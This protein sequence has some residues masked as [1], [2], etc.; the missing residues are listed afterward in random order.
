MTNIEA[1]VDNVGSAFFN[2]VPVVTVHKENIYQVKETLISDIQVFNNFSYL[3]DI[4]VNFFW[5]I[6]KLKA[7]D[8]HSIMSSVSVTFHSQTTLLQNCSFLAVDC[9]L[10]GLGERKRLNVAAVDERWEINHCTW[11]F[12]IILMIFLQV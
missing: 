4:D 8:V 6:W 7:F 2:K 5:V 12:D 11:N 3:C 1:N 10:S 9:E